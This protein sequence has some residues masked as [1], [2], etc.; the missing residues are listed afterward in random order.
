MTTRFHAA[1]AAPM[2][3]AAIVSLWLVRPAE[4]AAQSND[5]TG[6]DILCSSKGDVYSPPVK[7][8]SSCFFAN[9]QVIVCDSANDKCYEG[10]KKDA[11]A[12]VAG[13]A[14]VLRQL[15]LLN[16]KIDRLTA[17][18]QSLSSAARK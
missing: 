14:A 1:L 18:V 15:H 5:R 8:V 12:I 3:A 2:L 16:E 17:Q 13:D 4:T 10:K 7:G 11:K 9:G 6:L